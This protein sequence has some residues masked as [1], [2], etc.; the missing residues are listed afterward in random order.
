MNGAKKNR[1]NKERIKSI[2]QRETHL[3]VVASESFHRDSSGALWEA[4]E[5]YPQISSLICC[6]QLSGSM[7]LSQFN[8]HMV[9]DDHRLMTSEC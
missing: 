8:K 5:F 1:M 4:R 2:I 7:G 3:L 9:C 6:V